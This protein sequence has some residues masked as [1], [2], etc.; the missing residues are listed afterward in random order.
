MNVICNNARRCTHI[1]VC[2]HRSVH[3]YNKS[4]CNHNC[5]DTDV[6]QWYLFGN[7]YSCIEIKNIEV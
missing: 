4:I 6:G 1:G 5:L 2:G 3:R 7:K